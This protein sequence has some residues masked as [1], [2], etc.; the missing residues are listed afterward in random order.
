MKHYKKVP[1]KKVT[2]RKYF[3]NKSISHFAITS[4]TIPPEQITEEL[5]IQPDKTFRKGPYKRENSDKI[6]TNMYHLWEISSKEVVHEEESASPHIYYLKNR[7][8]SKLDILYRYKQDSQYE[9][10]IAIWLETEMGSM[11]FSFYKEELEFIN[12]ICNR[13]DCFLI[14]RTDVTVAD[15][16]P[17]HGS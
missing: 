6:Y 7:L 17:L 12:S 13:F 14:A 4:H 5:G 11:G 1:L 16:S 9:L 2:K 15:A 3:Y 10:I 8:K